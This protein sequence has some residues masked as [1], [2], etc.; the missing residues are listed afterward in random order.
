MNEKILQIPA[1]I[2]KVTSMSNRAMR[3]QVDT[4]QNV[5]D[6]VMAHLMSAVEKYGHFCFL[7]GDREVDSMDLIT[8]PP[9]KDREEDK[10]SP[11]TRLRGALFVLWQ[12]AGKKGDFEVFYYA[13]MENFISAVKDKLN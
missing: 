2:S 10:K 5:P 4:Q 13:K 11:S 9:L 7:V 12:Q 3:I 1:E 6:E 8:L